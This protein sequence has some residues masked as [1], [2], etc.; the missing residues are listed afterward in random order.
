MLTAKPAV[1]RCQTAPFK[2]H[3]MGMICRQKNF[4]DAQ[5]RGHA[6]LIEN[7]NGKFDRGMNR[8]GL[9]VM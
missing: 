9:A 3:H 6:N 8:A 4:S 5:E 2:K 7:A 1:L